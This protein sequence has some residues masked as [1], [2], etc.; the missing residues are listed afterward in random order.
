MKILISYL[1]KYKTLY[2]S[3][4]IYNYNNHNIPSNID[5]L[6]SKKKKSITQ[7]YIFVIELNS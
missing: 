2:F 6:P 5:Y 1:L 7:V 3:Y 4:I